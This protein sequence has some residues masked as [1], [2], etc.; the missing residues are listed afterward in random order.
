MTELNRRDFCGQ[1]ARVTCCAALGLMF[2]SCGG[3]SSPTAPGH[4]SM[5]PTV[6]GTR[7]TGG[8]AITIDSSSPLAAAG[9]AA[10]AQTPSGSFLV[11]HTGAETFVALSAL[12]THQACTITNVDNQTYVCPCHGSTFDLNGR[13]LGGPAPTSLRSYATQFADGVLTIAA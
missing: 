1:A 2:E 4:S 3:N 7:M 13:V 6:T 12:C 11:A 10:L 8:I 5:L 9:T